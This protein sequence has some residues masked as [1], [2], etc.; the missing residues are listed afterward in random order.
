MDQSNEDR[1]VVAGSSADFTAAA[2]IPVAATNNVSSDSTPPYLKL[3]VDCWEHI[4][5]Y[6]SFEDI[7]VMSGTCRAMQKLAGHYFNEFY[8]D[9]QYEITGSEVRGASAF[10]FVLRPDF[11]Q[12]IGDLEITD[13]SKLDYILDV[14][15]FPSLKILK[16]ELVHLNETQLGYAR[17]VLKNIENIELES[18]KISGN[19]FEQ[20]AKECPKLK[21]LSV[22]GCHTKD[23]AITRLFSQNYP[24]LLHL[25]FRSNRTRFEKFKMFLEKHSKLEHFSTNF[26]FLW[27]NRDWLIDTNVRLNML[28]IHLSRTDI[29]FDEFI[30]FMKALHERGFYKALFYK[31]FDYTGSNVNLTNIMYNLPALKRLS[32]YSGSGI[33][34][35]RLINLKQLQFFNMYDISEA[36]LENM[37][38]SLINLELLSLDGTYIRYISPFVRHSKKLKKIRIDGMIDLDNEHD[39]NVLDLFAFNEERK[40]LMGACPLTLSVKEEVY[41]PTKWCS[42]NL[43]LSHVK[44]QRLDILFEDIF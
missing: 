29:P 32:I 20:L 42:K 27:A 36:D 1:I 6:L 16:F 23:N 41:L 17:S 19:I 35:S 22:E 43:N 37:A 39:D 14:E 11:Y 34:F 13:R 9:L 40:K 18:C 15:T 7:H 31:C 44:V 26:E 5:D 28:A 2:A 12:F 25:Q 3:I 24:H 30:G 33:D 21:Y 4:L 38:K 8:P 10:S